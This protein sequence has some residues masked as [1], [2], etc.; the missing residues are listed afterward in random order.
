MRKS[1]AA[2]LALATLAPT[3]PSFAAKIKGDTTL[4]DSQTAGIKDKEHKHQAYDLFFE[5][6]GKSYT[7]RTDSNKSMNATDFVIGTALKY[8]LDGDKVKLETPEGKKVE[9]KVVRVEMTPSR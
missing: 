8:E 7:C 9:C 2:I 6:Q 1:A 3:L 5:A 4:K